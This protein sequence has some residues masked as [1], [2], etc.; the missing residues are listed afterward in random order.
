MQ[1][2]SSPPAQ[3]SDHPAPTDPELSRQCCCQSSRIQSHHSHPPVFALVKD[4]WAHWIQA[5]LTC[6]QSSHNHSTFL[7]VRCSDANLKLQQSLTSERP[8]AEKYPYNDVS[9]NIAVSSILTQPRV[10][11]NLAEKPHR[12]RTPP[13][14]TASTF[15]FHSSWNPHKKCPF[16]WRGNWTPSDTRVCAPSGISIGSAVFA[17]LICAPNTQ[18]PSA[19]LRSVNA[20][21]ARLVPGWVTVFGRVYHLGM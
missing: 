17:L 12:C 14:V 13:F 9:F 19:G 20:R 2:S 10:Q 4:N 15:G 16:S 5:P 18:A 8:V 1:L 3:V 21:R 7:S 6:L 11:S